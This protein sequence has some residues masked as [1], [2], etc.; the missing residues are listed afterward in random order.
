[1]KIEVRNLTSGYLKNTDVIKEISFSM[2]ESEITVL[3]GENGSGKSTIF[4]TILGFLKAKEGIVL[5]DNLDILSLSNYDRAKNVSYVPQNVIMPELSV[6]D[7]IAMGRIPYSFYHLTEEDKKKID[8]VISEFNLTQYK[9]K[10]CNELSGGLKQLVAI[11]RAIAQE[12]KLIILDEPTSNLDINNIMLVRKII[13]KI[14]KE[15]NIMVLLSIHDLNEAYALGDNFVFLRDGIVIDSG[16]IDTFTEEN[17]Y[18]T[19][20]RKGEIIKNDDDY[21]IKFKE[22]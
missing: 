6:Y 22:E 10:L 18:N 8:E 2:N 11:A 17:I 3:I 15:K 4:K 5:L 21:Y 12:P 19:F 13:R 7:V 1:M 9:D 20:L 16:N 14:A